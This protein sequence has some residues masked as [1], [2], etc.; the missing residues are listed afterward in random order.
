MNHG[1]L[2]PRQKTLINM[3]N[4]NHNMDL[5]NQETSG[6]KFSDCG[7]HRL[8][9]YRVWDIKKPL[10]MFIGLNPSTANADKDDPTINRVKQ[11]AAAN[12][13]GGVFMMNLFTFIS[14]DPKKLNLKEGNLPGADLYLQQIAKRC[15]AIVCAW[16][17]FGVMGRDNQV[18]ELF[19]Q[20][21]A[22]KINKNGSPK[23]PLYCKADQQLVNY[24][25]TG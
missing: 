19:P 12:G 6:A 5:F 8:M 13:F 21:I 14:T 11:I 25:T 4:L 23:H 2:K 17:N 16:G 10:V 15:K 3:L 7:K 22:L 1:Q 9:L 20:A 24:D 18:R